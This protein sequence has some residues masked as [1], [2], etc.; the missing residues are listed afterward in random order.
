MRSIKQRTKKNPLYVLHQAIRKV[1][2]NAIVKPRCVGG[3]TYQIP[4]EMEFA[5]RKALV[6][7]GD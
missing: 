7:V 4:I 3:S 1:T 2:H 6:I 5:Q